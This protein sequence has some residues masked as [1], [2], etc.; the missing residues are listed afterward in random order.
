MYHDVNNSKKILLSSRMFQSIRE[1]YRSTHFVSVV[2]E[3]LGCEE[4][5]AVCSDGNEHLRERVD[6]SRQLL[7]EPLRHRTDQPGMTLEGCGM[8][9]W[10]VEWSGGMWNGLVGCGMV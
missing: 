1:H 6:L 8:V 4:E 7:R 2:H 5:A 9:W 3:S 10:D